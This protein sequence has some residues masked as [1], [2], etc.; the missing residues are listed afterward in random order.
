MLQALYNP[1]DAPGTFFADARV[2]E[3]ACAS[4]LSPTISTTPSLQFWNSTSILLPPLDL[5]SG[6]P[7]WA[8]EVQVAVATVALDAQGQQLPDSFYPYYGSTIRSTVVPTAPNTFQSE[9]RPYAIVQL[10]PNTHGG[11]AASSAAVVTGGQLSNNTEA[12]TEQTAQPIVHVTVEQIQEGGFVL[13]TTLSRDATAPVRFAI[14]EG[15]V[16]TKVLGTVPDPRKAVLCALGTCV[17]GSE[18]NS[19]PEGTVVASGSL[20][21]MSRGAYQ[22][23]LCFH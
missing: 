10:A 4:L 20:E 1:T 11:G 5:V 15:D 22:N 8:S 6:N 17:D 3:H 14:V 21:Q 9:F 7:Q 16:A 2:D 19:W 18:S 12:Q 23:R 13:R